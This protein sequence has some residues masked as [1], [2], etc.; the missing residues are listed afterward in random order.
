MALVLNNERK[1]TSDAFSEVIKGL[2]S[3]SISYEPLFNKWLEVIEP[4]AKHTEL[5]KEWILPLKK[6][7][8]DLR[9]NVSPETVDSF[10]WQYRRISFRIDTPIWDISYNLFYNIDSNTLSFEGIAD[11]T[12]F[13]GNDEWSFV[14][15]KLQSKLGEAIINYIT[16]ANESNKT[17]MLNELA[18]RALRRIKS[19][20]MNYIKS[21]ITNSMDVFD[22]FR[23][24]RILGTDIGYPKQP[25]QFKA[26]SI[27]KTNT[28]IAEGIPEEKA[29]RIA[30]EEVVEL[31]NGDFRL[32]SD[33]EHTD[34][35]LL[36]FTER[37]GYECIDQFFFYT[38]DGSRKDPNKRYVKS[39]L[40]VM[41]DVY[42]SEHL[43]FMIKVL[44]YN[45][46]VEGLA[47]VVPDRFIPI[48]AIFLRD[49]RAE[50]LIEKWGGI[51]SSRKFSNC[52]VINSTLTVEKFLRTSHYDF[53]DDYAQYVVDSEY[54]GIQSVIKE[55]T[56]LG[57]IEQEI[58]DSYK[59]SFDTLSRYSELLEGNDFLPEDLGILDNKHNVFYCPGLSN[60]TLIDTINRKE[61]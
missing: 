12:I 10:S 45:P 26:L 50:R 7:V 59:K 46:D 54:N 49:E 3:G 5:F 52:T 15:S 30:Y 2:E 48:L 58:V 56:N 4:I 9:K 40:E 41:P 55:M 37:Y 29:I 47:N 53:S 31:S 36:I 44:S 25:Y 11:K 20:Y 27:G 57:T 19:E 16:D 1:S 6:C 24:G 28:Y 33:L 42:Y 23:V 17:L 39:I 22:N 14:S 34:D 35:L 13:I 38:R 43:S 18:K 32:V 61:E 8:D 51:Y 60:G 21:D